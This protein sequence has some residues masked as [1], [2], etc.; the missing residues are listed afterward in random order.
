MKILKLKLLNSLS[1]QIILLV[2]KKLTNIINIFLGIIFN[3]Y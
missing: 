1:N 3:L 2:N